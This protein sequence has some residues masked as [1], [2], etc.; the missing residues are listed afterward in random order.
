L[1][2]TWD[3]DRDPLL[4]LRTGDRRPFE[5]FVAAE[6][7]TFLA[8]FQRLGAGR[9]QAEDLVQDLFLKLFRH[10]ETYE[11][12]GRFRAFAFRVARNAWIDGTRRE[13][14]R[15]ESPEGEAAV[16]DHEPQDSGAAEHPADAFAAR[17][18]AERAR[19]ALS[20]LSESHRMV[21]ELGAL[22][23]LP[24]S[25]IAATL[26]IPEGTVKSRMFHA[27][28]RLREALERGAS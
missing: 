4:A 10:A 19:A 8:F 5:A 25:E 7:P 27:V 21:F 26:G 2:E 11:P 12:Q 20:S 24:Y 18:E 13:A 6:T 14:G 1:K 17:E 23:E 28:R 3:F 16:L 22:Q 15:R 9:A